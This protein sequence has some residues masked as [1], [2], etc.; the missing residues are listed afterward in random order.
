MKSNTGRRSAD[1]TQND[2]H[3]LK[4]NTMANFKVGQ[5]VVCIKK[6]LGMIYK[7]GLKANAPLPVLGNTYIITHILPDGFLM[8]SGF[9]L[10]DSF[11]PTKFEPLKYN[12]ATAEILEK[13][14]LT[15]EKADVEIKELENA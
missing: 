4:Q 15:E 10:L 1:L 13:F 14:K 12:S 2:K 5:R 9:S 11:D 6:F 8:L 3:K 7:T